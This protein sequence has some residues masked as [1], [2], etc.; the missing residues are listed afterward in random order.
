MGWFTVYCKERL[1]WWNPKPF[2]FCKFIFYCLNHTTQ[3]NKSLFILNFNFPSLTVYTSNK[4]FKKREDWLCQ[5]YKS[6]DR[7]VE[8]TILKEFWK[9]FGIILLYKVTFMGLFHVILISRKV[10]GK[11]YDKNFSALNHNKCWIGSY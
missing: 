6:K 9:K 10:L 11:N 2:F 8:L 5:W 7:K 3:E 4:S 1:D